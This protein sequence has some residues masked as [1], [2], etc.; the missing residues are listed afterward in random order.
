[1]GWES[2]TM[3]SFSGITGSPKTMAPTATRSRRN[4]HRGGRFPTRG[5]VGN[6]TSPLVTLE[7]LRE[8]K[9]GWVFYPP[10]SR[11]RPT[12]KMGVNGSVWARE[13]GKPAPTRGAAPARRSP[14]PPPPGRERSR[15]GANPATALPPPRRAAGTRRGGGDGHGDSRYPH[16]TGGTRPPPPNKG[17][18][19]RRSALASR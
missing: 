10:V 19:G 2:L 6:A 5:Q 15:V 3:L 11:V 17:G 13:D 4:A 12:P 8:V 14:P 16:A 1:M 9:D 18:T 7:T